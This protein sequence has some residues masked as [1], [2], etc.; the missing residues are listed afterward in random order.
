MHGV[1]T[2]VASPRSDRFGLDDFNDF[3]ISR[4]GLGVDDVDA[5]RAD[6]R[7]NEVATLHVR[8][9]VVRA[10]ARA[11]GVPTKVVEFIA[12]VRHVDLTDL[13][14]VGGR[15]GIDID[16]SYGVGA[17]GEGGIEEC[18]VGELFGWSF[19]GQ[20]GRWVEGRVGPPQVHDVV[21]FVFEFGR[22]NKKPANQIAWLAGLR[23]LHSL[24]ASGMADAL[25]VP[26]NQNVARKDSNTRCG[27][28]T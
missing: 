11:A 13:P 6:A 8:V 22:K 2:A 3:G 4:V 19:A 12:S 26:L 17:A 1:G 9:S 28:E 10:E 25:N 23:T 16:Y 5:R 14:A 20:F 21:P 24:D 15:R 7:N 27:A 18:D